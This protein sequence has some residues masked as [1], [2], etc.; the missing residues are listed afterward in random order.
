MPV[1]FVTSFYDIY[2]GDLN[3]QKTIEWRVERFNEIAGTGINIC[4]YTCPKFAKYI[5]TVK[6]PNVYTGAVAP[7][8]PPTP[9]ELKDDTNGSILPVFDSDISSNPI[10]AG[11]MRGAAVTPLWIATQSAGCQLPDIKNE[12]KDT[13]A[14]MIIINSKTQF[15]TDAIQKN[16]FGTTHFAW[17]DFNI[18]HVLFNK[19]PSLSYL[20]DLGQ[21][22]FAPKMFAIPGCWDHKYNNIH[23][24]HVT[25]CIFWRFCGGFFIG[26]AESILR[27][28]ELYKTKY[29]EFINAHKKLVWE[30]NFW[31]WLEVNSDWAPEWYFAGHDDT[32]LTN[33][34]ASYFS[35]KLRDLGSTKTEYNYPVIPGY[36]PGSA[37]YLKTGGKH[38]LNTRYASYWYYPDGGYMFYDGTDIIR[39]KNVLSILDGDSLIPHG[40]DEM[41]ESTINLPR[42]N[43]YSVGIEDIRLYEDESDGRVKYIGTTVGY[44]GTGGNRMMIGNYDYETW[45]YSDSRL[46][47]PP[48]ETWCEKNWVPLPGGKKFVYKWAPMEIGEIMD[49]NRLEIVQR[50][51]DTVNIPLFSKMKGSAPFIEY[52]GALIGIIH[53]SEETKPRHYFH[54]IVVLDKETFRP[55]RYSEPFV[56]ENIGIE[57]CIGFDVSVSDSKYL[58]WISQF[59]REPAL[60]SIDIDKIKC[61]YIV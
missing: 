5:D 38:I 4:V 27:F 41:D 9:V 28:G 22:T 46:I 17:I 34:S 24:G 6:Y 47:Q 15:M 1:T 23:I 54:M 50:Y 44:H 48:T 40:Y 35:P 13:A 33:L 7:R 49:G 55:V 11:G 14:Y 52:D 39:T 21:R 45:T 32:I 30:V 25:E 56:F 16:P 61:N 37:S 42:H 2:N 59:D 60:I 31:A 12:A 43:T 36:H 3:A 8:T 20:K 19:A 58:F 29:P 51:E 53:F 18:S 57:F 26:D 10:E